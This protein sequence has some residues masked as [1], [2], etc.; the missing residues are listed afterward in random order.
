MGLRGSGRSPRL[1][2]HPGRRGRTKLLESQHTGASFLGSHLGAALG[3][4]GLSGLGLTQ[5]LTPCPQPG[6]RRWMTRP[7]RNSPGPWRHC[8][9]TCR[10]SWTC[11]GGRVSSAAPLPS[12]ASSR[13]FFPVF[14]LPLH[15][16]QLCCD[17]AKFSASFERPRGRGWFS[18]ATRYWSSLCQNP[19]EDASV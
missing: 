17:T 6:P 18:Q 4:S 8:R 5:G 10:W 1:A 15:P 14:Q 16:S 3:V 13:V 2:D 11:A 9:R 19:V 12:P 7:W